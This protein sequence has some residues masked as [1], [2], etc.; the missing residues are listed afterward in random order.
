MDLTNVNKLGKAILLSVV[1]TTANAIAPV[2][3]EPLKVGEEAPDFVLA[4]TT[5]GEIR[6]SDFREEK[7]VLIEFYHA[8]FGPS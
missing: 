8:D 3:A 6:L 7:M 2:Q 1:V 5:G 4:A